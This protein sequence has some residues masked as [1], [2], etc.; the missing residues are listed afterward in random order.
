MSLSLNLQITN[1]QTLVHTREQNI[2]GLERDLNK[3][4]NHWEQYNIAN[5]IMIEKDEL[6]L[7]K[8]ELYKLEETLYNENPEMSTCS[9]CKRYEETDGMGL[10]GRCQYD[11]QFVCQSCDKKC[12]QIDDLDDGLCS[13]CIE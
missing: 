4:D 6:Q 3:T 9:I 10:C 11:Q 12:E 1:F 13:D 8:K 5:Q 2:L 7:Y